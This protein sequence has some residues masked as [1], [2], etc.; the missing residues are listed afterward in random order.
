MTVDAFAWR[1]VGRTDLRVTQ[2]GF[3]TATL[4]DIRVR[5]SE[6]QS[7]ATIE[8]GWAAGVGYFDTAPWY[9]RTKRQHR[10]GQVLRGK[11]RESFVLSTKVGRVFHRP[12]Q[13]MEGED[14]WAGPLAFDL[15]FDYTRAGVVRSY[16]D[17]RSRHSAQALAPSPRSRS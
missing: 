13:P 7:A 12:S 15:D 9:G 8:A 10:L 3:G 4:G 11:P 1:Q 14:A 16:E 5:V 2:L 17:S 6:A